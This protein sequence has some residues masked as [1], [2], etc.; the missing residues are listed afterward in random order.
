[1]LQR[2]QRR[3][4]VKKSTAFWTVMTLGKILWK[5][6]SKIIPAGCCN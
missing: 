6:K 2:N 1:M 3:Y 4:H 5:V